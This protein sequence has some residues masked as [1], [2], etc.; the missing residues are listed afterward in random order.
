MKIVF[1]YIYSNPLKRGWC[2][3][4][5]DTI[6]ECRLQISVTHTMVTLQQG[7]ECVKSDGSATQQYHGGFNFHGPENSRRKIRFLLEPKS[8]LIFYQNLNQFMGLNSTD[9]VTKILSF[10]YLVWVGMNSTKECVKIFE[11][12]MNDMVTSITHLNI[13]GTNR[14]GIVLW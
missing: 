8:K 1:D 14:W 4:C 10:K 6:A 7:V 5:T 12:C 13:F 2:F 11:C 9:T 3:I